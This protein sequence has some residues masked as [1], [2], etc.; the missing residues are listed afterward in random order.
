MGKNFPVPILEQY[1]ID[2][3]KPFCSAIVI[4]LQHSREDELHLHTS[5][6]FFHSGVSP[7]I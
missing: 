6:A 5:L 7:A 1:A 2:R 3:V 4:A